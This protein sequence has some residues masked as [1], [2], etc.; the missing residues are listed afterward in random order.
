MS[1][2]VLEPDGKKRLPPAAGMGRKKGVQ[3]KVTRQ[4]KEMIL[5]ALDRAGGADYLLECARNPK[6]A[7]AFLTL[8]GKAMPLQVTGADGGPIKVA[9][10]EIVA[11]KA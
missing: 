6:L 2:K 1:N 4:V 5:E 8:V 3:N 10:I 7:P 9:R 11:M